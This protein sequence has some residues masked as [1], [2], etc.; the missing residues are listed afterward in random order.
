MWV[1]VTYP[2]SRMEARR[3]TGRVDASTGVQIV[4]IVRL[5]LDVMDAVDVVMGVVTAD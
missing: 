1:C 3:C 2:Y 5:A 4:Q